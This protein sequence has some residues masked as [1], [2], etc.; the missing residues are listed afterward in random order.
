[1]KTLVK[2]FWWFTPYSAIYF[3]STLLFLELFCHSANLFIFLCWGTLFFFVS[4]IGL[5]W[6]LRFS[7][8]S[9]ISKSFLLYE[10]V[11]PAAFVIPYSLS[12]SLQGLAY[13]SF[14]F[15]GLFSLS[16]MSRISFYLRLTFNPSLLLG[17]GLAR[18][19]LNYSIHTSRY[20]FWII[21]L[22]Q[23]ECYERWCMLL[24]IFCELIYIH[25]LHDNG[26][27]K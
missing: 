7:R 5:F 14:R 2:I 13:E 24:C 3:I 12:F 15:L 10:A 1:M 23:K 27:Y 22:N 26:C 25:I 6:I 16:S 18:G 9:T 8:F 19:T 11:F 21:S 20:V 4:L 17:L